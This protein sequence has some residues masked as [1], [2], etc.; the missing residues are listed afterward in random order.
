M[1]DNKK[2][3]C[4]AAGAI[5]ALA[6]V[7]ATVFAVKQHKKKQNALL[8]EELD[9]SLDDDLAE[10]ANEVEET[11]PTD[12]EK[13]EPKEEPKAEAEEQPEVKNEAEPVAEEKTAESDTEKADA[14]A[15]TEE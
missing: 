12:E 5:G 15:K 13:A 10:L 14:P 6:A 8:F 7:S 4:A 9:C 3:I 11:K 2:L 1:D